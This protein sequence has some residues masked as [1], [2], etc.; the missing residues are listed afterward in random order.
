[1]AHAVSNVVPEHPVVDSR[2]GYV[3]E[4]SLIEK[5]IHEQSKCPMTGEP[6][7][8]EDLIPVKSGKALKPRH[9]PLMSIPGLI[10]ALHQVRRASRRHV[11]HACKFGMHSSS[12][13]SICR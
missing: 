1:V 2:R 6:L 3:Y 7:A 10:G 12:A 8:L 13:T 11:R 5:Y 9:A 4:K